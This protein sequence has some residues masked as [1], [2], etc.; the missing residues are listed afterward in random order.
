MEHLSARART[1]G[2]TAALLLIRTRAGAPLEC[3]AQRRWRLPALPM[4]QP[5]HRTPPRQHEHGLL[6]PIARRSCHSQWNTANH[7]CYTGDDVLCMRCFRGE[8]RWCRLPFYLAGGARMASTAGSH[9]SH[10]LS[11]RDRPLECDCSSHLRRPRASECAR[12]TAQP[13]FPALLELAWLTVFFMYIGV[14]RIQVA[15]PSGGE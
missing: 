8:F 6:P 12:V 3:A 4:L 5:A 7:L 11:H 10:E 14:H 9:A 13:T 2:G 15:R 1:A